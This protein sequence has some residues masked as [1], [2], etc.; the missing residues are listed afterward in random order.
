MIYVSKKRPEPLPLIRTVS[1]RE[2]ADYEK[3]VQHL[4]KGSADG[5]KK[6]L[7]EKIVLSGS[8]V[9]NELVFVRSSSN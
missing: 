7:F 2:L 6:V 1:E 4:R 3:R 8:A 9:N 5:T